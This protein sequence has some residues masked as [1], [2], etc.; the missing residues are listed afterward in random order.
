VF[1]SSSSLF[2]EKPIFK[3]LPASEQCLSREKNNTIKIYPVTHSLTAMRKS[4]YTSGTPHRFL[5]VWISC[6]L[7]GA[8]QIY[9]SRQASEYRHEDDHDDT[10]SQSSPRFRTHQQQPV[11]DCDFFLAES[12]IPHGGLGVYT[13]KSIAKDEPAQPF[14][15][16]CVYVTNADSN[17]GTEIK[18]HT[19]QDFRFGAQWLGGDNVRGQCMGLVTTFNSMGIKQYAS[20]RPSADQALIHSNGGLDRSRDPGAGAITHYFGA[21]SAARR[22]LQPGEELLLWDK[23]WGGS[24]YQ[25]EETDTLPVPPLRSPKWLQKHGMCVDRIKPGPATDPSMGRGAFA[26]RH[27]SKGTVVAPA[28]VQIFFNRTKFLASVSSD[29]AEAKPSPE[30]LIVN[31][32][33]Q[34]QNST[35]LLYPYGAGV[36]LINHSRDPSKI[37]VK[38]QW[39][40][41]PMSHTSWLDDELSMEQFE[42]IQHPGGLIIEFVA[43]RDIAENEEIYMYYGQ[44]WDDAW[45][46]H[47]DQWKPDP[48]AETYMYPK[49]MDTMLPFRTKK[50][51]ETDPYPKNLRTVCES[52]NG[53]SKAP[54]NMTN[55]ENNV[56]RWIGPGIWWPENLVGCTILDRKERSR[57]NGTEYTYTVKWTRRVAEGVKTKIY[58]TDVPHRAIHFVDQPGQ[59][60]QHLQNAFRH[61]IGLPLD[62]TPSKWM[63]A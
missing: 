33:F 40:N 55:D 10:A 21:T 22:D 18:T 7:L 42:K 20:A 35:I 56:V 62:M 23:G 41:H 37:N 36:G 48:S 39:S 32:C 46:S 52:Q 4:S 44:E 26:N 2:S 63:D 54:L 49:D 59:N 9:Q 19:W 12:S 8:S 43:T 28:P 15:D 29:E 60:D 34:P 11:M 51:Q 13:A 57:Q 3:T 16:I 38:L 61:P 24:S 45:N 14:P 47:V 30:E 53:K 31:Y 17:R 58:E 50:E 27:L 1:Q 5:A 6:A 25:D